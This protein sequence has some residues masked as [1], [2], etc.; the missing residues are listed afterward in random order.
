[1]QINTIEGSVKSDY[2]NV[3]LGDKGD[4]T[5]NTGTKADFIYAGE[6]DDTI[7]LTLNDEGDFVLN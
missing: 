1:M 2:S 4:E 7:N 3:L 6:G 5:F